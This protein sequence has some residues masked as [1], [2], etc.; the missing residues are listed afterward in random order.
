MAERALA[1]PLDASE[2]IEIA[3]AEYKKRL[4]SLSPL[5]GMKE[6]AGFKIKFTDKVELYRMG[7]NGGGLK[8]T[9]A[10]GES[11][12]GEVTEDVVAVEA[13]GEYTTM[14]HKDGVNGVRMDYDMPLTVETSDGK[15][16]RI[17]KKVRIKDAGK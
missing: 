9:L 3:V 14:D 15:G 11:T 16:G 7:S 8:E 6:Y 13:P 5:T 17:T 2:I 4:L 10:W 12:H 1:N